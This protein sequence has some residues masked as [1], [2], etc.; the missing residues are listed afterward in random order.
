MAQFFKGFPREFPQFLFELPFHNT[1]SEQQE[2]AQRYKTLI[3]QPLRELYQDLVPVVEDIGCGLETQPRRCVCSPY[4]DRR[5][6]PDVPLK[7]Y[8]YLKFRQSGR[9]EDTAG[10]FFDMGCDSYSLGLRFY[11]KTP[12]GMKKRREAIA[13]AP[14][15]SADA[16]QKALEGDFQLYGE[17]YKTDHCPEVSHPLTKQML[18]RKYFC[19]CAERPVG[20]TVFTPAL[21]DE[22]ASGFYQMAPLLEQMIQA[23]PPEMPSSPGFPMDF[24]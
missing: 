9:K 24:A 1:V 13:D 21:F 10:L 15:K 6:S 5:F 19:V 8:M 2:N 20:E 18:N 12:R 11:R 3:L 17:E 23:L 22:I 16:L 4:T 14:E 7:D